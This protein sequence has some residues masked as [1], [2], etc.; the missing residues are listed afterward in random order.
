MH[1]RVPSL[2]KKEEKEIM[3]T[4][5]ALNIGFVNEWKPLI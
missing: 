1:G 5:S 4:H 2:G 3:G